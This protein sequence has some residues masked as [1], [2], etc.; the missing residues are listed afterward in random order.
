MFKGNLKHPFQSVWIAFGLGVLLSSF[1]N[2]AYHLVFTGASFS[3]AS[4]WFSVL[5]IIYPF[6]ALVI[7]V[8]VMPFVY[9]SQKFSFSGPA[10]AL[11]MLILVVTIGY[12]SFDHQSPRI[13][14]FSNA[15]SCFTIFYY[16][17]YVRQPTNE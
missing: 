15:I 11:V 13:I 2:A 4:D 14:V 9:I 12:L 16:L 1:L 10:T 8:I 17:A 5:G 3:S 6:G 7:I